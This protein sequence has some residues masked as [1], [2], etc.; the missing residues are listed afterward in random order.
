ML[1]AM[2]SIHAPRFSTRLCTLFGGT[3]LLLLPGCPGEEP[4]VDDSASSSTSTT[5]NNPPDSTS[6]RRHRDEVGFNEND[7]R[8]T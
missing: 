4:P 2:P 5:T 6:L 8:I 7:T 1:C 3:A